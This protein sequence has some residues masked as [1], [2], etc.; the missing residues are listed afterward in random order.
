M[1]KQLI[2][3]KDSN[4]NRQGGL[5][6]RSQAK[7]ASGSTL[8]IANNGKAYKPDKLSE[9]VTRYVKLSCMKRGGA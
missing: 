4:G 7:I 8:F 2:Y 5:M 6:N 1:G 9:M 3:T